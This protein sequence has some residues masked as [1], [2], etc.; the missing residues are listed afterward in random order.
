MRHADA[1]IM[2]ENEHLM[3]I[4]P[5]YAAE[6]KME[7]VSVKNL[8]EYISTCLWNVMM[9]WSDEPLFMSDLTSLA[10]VP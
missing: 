8:N 9:P 6:K 3:K 10:A 1:C 5:K 2:F 7:K 4:I